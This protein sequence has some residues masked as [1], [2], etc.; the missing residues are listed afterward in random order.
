[1]L[2]WTSFMQLLHFPVRLS[3]TDSHPCPPLSGL[4]TNAADF[5]LEWNPEG[6]RRGKRRRGRKKQWEWKKKKTCLC[7]SDDIHRESWQKMYVN[8]LK[9]SMAKEEFTEQTCSHLISLEAFFSISQCHRRAERQEEGYVSPGCRFLSR[10]SFIHT[11]AVSKLLS[12]SMVN[13]KFG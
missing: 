6:H 12:H 11:A 7:Y 2:T 13:D 5:F 8:L 4:L 9:S 1:M 3:F 10:S